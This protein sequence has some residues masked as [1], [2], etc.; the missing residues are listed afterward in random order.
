[1]VR[2]AKKDDIDR[3]AQIWYEANVKSHYFIPKEYWAGQFDAVKEMLPLSEL[4]VY[5][6]K[7]EVTGFIG[8]DGDYIAGIFVSID[9]QSKGI[10]TQLLNYVKALKTE[11]SLNVY[12]KN[13]RAVR[14][15]VREAFV[16][17]SEGTD[18]LTGEKEYLMIWRK[19]S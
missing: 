1:M 13:E 15:Y 6:E 10:G 7:G 8:L 3:I 18:E 16:I 9:A 12:Q 17:Q 11:L 2:K 14:F 4:Y 19:S 5:E